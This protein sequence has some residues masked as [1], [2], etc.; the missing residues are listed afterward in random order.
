MCGIVGFLGSI[1]SAGQNSAV[2]QRRADLIRRRGP[3]DDG[4]W[5]EVGIALAQRRLAVVVLSPA[6]HP[7]MFS[8]RQRYVAVFNGEIRDYSQ[9]R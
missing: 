9:S 5:G 3:D 7:P 8:Q 6:G 2:L 1:G 4:V